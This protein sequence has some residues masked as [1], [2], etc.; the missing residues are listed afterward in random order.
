MN[1]STRIREIADLAGNIE[2]KERLLTL[3]SE[4]EVQHNQQN[5]QWQITFGQL[6]NKVEEQFEALRFDMDQAF[7]ESEIRQNKILELM[8]ALQEELRRGHADK[9]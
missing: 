4:F 2:V 5:N 1:P 8:E 3:A 6:Q 9:Q 7:G